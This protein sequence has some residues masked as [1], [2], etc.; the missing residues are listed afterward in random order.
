MNEP[1]IT[2]DQ[3]AGCLAILR[4]AEKFMTAAEIAARLGI[5]GSHETQRRHIRALVK[6]LRDN[7]SM[8]IANNA[9]GYWLTNDEAK[10][11][12]YVEHRAIDAK[13]ILAE[14]SRRKQMLADTK[15]QGMLFNM[16]V[17]AGCATVGV[18]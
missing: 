6:E 10:W 18:N 16:R 2:T 12:D 14:V 17:P 1:N 9:E 13:V 8:I 3:V 5:A 11:R 7:G 4:R 15:D